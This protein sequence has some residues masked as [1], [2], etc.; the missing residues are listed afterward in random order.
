MTNA[1]VRRELPPWAIISVLAVVI[2]VLAVLVFRAVKPADSSNHAVMI[3][4]GSKS[5]Y[6]NHYSMPGNGAA[7]SQANA[8]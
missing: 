7:S 5:S 4:P 1:S 8:K 6:L 2:I 3:G